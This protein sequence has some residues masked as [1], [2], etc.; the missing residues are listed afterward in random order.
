MTTLYVLDVPE[1][2]AV[3]TVAEEDPAVTVGHRGDYFEITADGPIVIDRRATGCRHAVWY[4]CVAGVA[5][6]GRITQHDKNALR[7]DPV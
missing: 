5:R 6:D 3:A 2:V 7:V 1:N 4:S